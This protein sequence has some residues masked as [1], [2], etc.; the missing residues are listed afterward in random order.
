M[1]DD[2]D[3]GV[4]FNNIPMKRKLNQTDLRLYVDKVNN[5]M[6]INPD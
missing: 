2:V 3:P 4:L 1:C 6:K 5:V